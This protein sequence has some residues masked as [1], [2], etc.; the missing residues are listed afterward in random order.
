MTSAYRNV[1]R[2]WLATGIILLIISLVMPVLTYRLRVFTGDESTYFAMALSF[3]RDGD[4]V[5]EQ[6]DL[7]RVFRYFPD[8][9]Q[10]IFLKKGKSDRLYYAKS[11][12]YPLLTAPFV[13]LFDV[14]GFIFFNVLLLW[15]CAGLALRWIKAHDWPPWT[16]A[17][18]VLFFFMASVLP[19]YVIWFTPEIFNFAMVFFALTLWFTPGAPSKW[20][21]RVSLVAGLFAA[22]LATVSKP[23][24]IVCFLV[25]GLYLLWQRKWKSLVAATLIGGILVIGLFGYY[26]TVTGDWNF[27]GG[28][29][30]TFYGHFPL[31][32][33][34][35]TFENLGVYHS[36]DVNYRKEYYI[37]GRTLFLDVLY[38]FFGR[39][40]GLLWYFTPAIIGLIQGLRRRDL[41]RILALLGFSLVAFLF[42]ITQPNNYLGGGG[43]LGN[44]YFTS[45]YP[46]TFLMITNLPQLS[47]WFLTAVVAGTFSG[48][49]LISPFMSARFPWMYAQSRIHRLLPLEYTLLENLPSNTLPRAL[50][51]EFPSPENPEFFVY[52]L[53]DGFYPKEG[54]GFWVR[55]GRWVEFVIKR[56]TPLQPLQISILNGAQPDHLVRLKVG[57]QSWRWHLKP[58]QRVQVTVEHPQW[59]KV[60]DV[61][62]LPVEITTTKGFIPAYV[63]KGNRDRRILGVYVDLSQ[64]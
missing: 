16:G 40:S 14:N 56:K 7:Y 22:A 20:S 2:L 9:P 15:L 53:N 4:I 51:I 43:T 29:R 37:D 50:H 64:P 57:N 55:G 17:G 27:Q 21:N 44:R 47:R 6:K 45:V 35:A 62:M 30:K 10:G 54:S 24:N 3:A 1:F 41:V 28:E 61:W 18:F 38:Y 46:W 39:Y 42:I 25:I 33:P 26:H 52:F 36:A 19:A 8:G 23:P 58:R 49:I 48:P 11:Y 63:E 34:R 5:Y 31:E 13:R 32:S 59:M 12:I 60:R